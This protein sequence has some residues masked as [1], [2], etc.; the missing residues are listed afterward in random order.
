MALANFFDKATLAASQLLRSVTSVDF[1]RRLQGISVCVAV[2]NDQRLSFE[3]RTCLELTTNLLARF[4]P[5]ISFALPTPFED[6][7]RS[8]RTLASEINPAIEFADP[9]TSN[10]VLA[11][12]E[13]RPSTAAAYLHL[14]S[15][16]WIAKVST[17]TTLR[18]GDSANPFGAAAAASLAAANLFRMVFAAE[19]PNTATDTDCNLSLLTYKHEHQTSLQLELKDIDLGT[20]HFVGLGAV[21]SAAIWC[22]ARCSWLKGTVHLV[23]P[24]EVTLSNLQRYVLCAQVDASQHLKKV[25]IAVKALEKNPN[26]KGL[27]HLGSWGEYLYKIGNWKLDQLAVAVD[28]AAARRDVQASSPRELLN[29]WTGPN[30]DVGISR[31][32]S[33]G[34]TACLMCLYMPETGGKN[35][36]QI[37]AESL[38]LTQPQHLL[39]VRRL[40]HTAEPLNEE[41]IRQIAALNNVAA[42]ALLSFAGQPLIVFYNE[43]ICGGLMLRLGG[44]TTPEMEVPMAFQS[45]IAGTMLAAGLVSRAAKL[46]IIPETTTRFSMLQPVPEFLSFNIERDPS[47]KCICHDSDF[48][49][50][51]QQKYTS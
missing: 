45:A 28:S 15:E 21:G 37:V 41:T 42:D 14:G 9:A 43:A 31:H 7:G 48:L 40:L 8:L 32:T 44:S 16:G 13:A 38:N 17:H 34:K 1:E 4:Y 30:G 19:L 46:H 47:E 27:P 3:L 24:Q 50:R 25:D 10:Y 29:S 2:G 6:F 51:Y 18:C 20:T 36:D 33:F 11:V 35:L 5:T 22:L 23:D 12:G 26:L 49:A 39:V